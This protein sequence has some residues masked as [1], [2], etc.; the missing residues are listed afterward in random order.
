[1]NINENDHRIGNRKDYSVYSERRSNKNLGEIVSPN[2]INK[3]N[4]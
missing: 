1:M 4:I 2:N 3:E